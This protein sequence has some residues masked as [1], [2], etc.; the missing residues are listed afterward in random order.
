METGTS[1]IRLPANKKDCMFENL[2]Q[3]KLTYLQQALAKA[4]MPARNI[5]LLKK[6][7][8]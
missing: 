1:I 2:S 5:P 7:R 4:L 6:K 8:G 3:I